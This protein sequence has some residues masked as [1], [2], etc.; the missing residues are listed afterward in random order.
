MQFIPVYTQ[1]FQCHTIFQKM[2]YAD[3]IISVE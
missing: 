1:S 3:N 2:W